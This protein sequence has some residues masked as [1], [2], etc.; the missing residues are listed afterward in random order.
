MTVYKQLFQIQSTNG[1]KTVGHDPNLLLL[2]LAS[3]GENWFC[4][5]SV[6][7]DVNLWTLPPR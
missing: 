6:G 7:K 2:I 5:F 4:V 1:Q 3:D